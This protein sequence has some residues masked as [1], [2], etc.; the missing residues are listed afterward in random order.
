VSDRKYVIKASYGNDS[1]ALMQWMADRGH[2]PECYVVHNE[3]G[4]ARSTWP[5]RVVRGERW[6]ASLGMK[7]IRTR[8]ISHHAQWEA[9]A[10]I[11]RER[12]D[13]VQ[14]ARAR[15]RELDG[16][17][18]QIFEG[19]ALLANPPLPGFIDDGSGLIPVFRLKQGFPRHGQQFCTFH[20]KI[21]PS[22]VF[23]ERADHHGDMIVVVGIRRQ[24]SDRRANWPEW[25]EESPLD[26]GRSLWAPLVRMREEERD[27]L[28]QRAGFEVLPHRSDECSPCVNATRDDLRRT[29]D[30]A[31]DVLEELET[32][33]S[34]GHEVPR[35]MFRRQSG[36][37]ETVAW[38]QSA[39]RKYV[40]GQSFLF[41]CDAG[42][43]GL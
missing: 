26:L 29:E 5:E 34:E 22:W 18:V 3:T 14:A 35:R 39:P 40:E 33:L 37:R 31:I 15:V 24:E 25:A 12:A 32:D 13:Y 42:F 23:Y 1:I 9:V 6:A 8:I 16:L 30:H 17:G 38:A 7:P 4:L 19:D 20:G 2:G 43:C 27:D 11:D 28:V 21:R 36:I 10:K 41:G